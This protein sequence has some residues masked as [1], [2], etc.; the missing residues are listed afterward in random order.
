MGNGNRN[1]RVRIRLLM[2][3]RIGG[4]KIVII[5]ERSMIRGKWP[6]GWMRTKAAVPSEPSAKLS[7]ADL[8]PKQTVSRRA[9][10]LTA[11]TPPARL[12]ERIYRCENDVERKKKEKKNS[13]GKKWIEEEITKS[14][15][16][17]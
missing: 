14:L 3:K 16:G 7:Q 2:R 5:I 4:K 8:M 12:E 1:P 15:K 6:C 10:K 9:A 17:R 13:K 11:P